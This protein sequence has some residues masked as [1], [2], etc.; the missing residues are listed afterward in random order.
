MI[1]DWPGLSSY[2]SLLQLNSGLQPNVQDQ[3]KQILFSDWENT[4]MLFQ[5]INPYP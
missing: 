3:T 5:N 2:R 4:C 1:H